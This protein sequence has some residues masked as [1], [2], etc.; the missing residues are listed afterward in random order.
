MKTSY[1]NFAGQKYSLTEN[2]VKDMD[3]IADAEHKIRKKA[4]EMIKDMDFDVF[5]GLKTFDD[6]NGGF[7]KAYFF[8]IPIERWEIERINKEF[9]AN[10]QIGIYYNQNSKNTT[11]PFK[12]EITG[13]DY[14]HQ[15]ADYLERSGFYDVEVTQASG[16]QGIDIIA[17]KGGKKYGI[18]CKY[19]KGSVGNKAV[20][21]AFTGAKFYKCDIAA[22]MT[23]GKFTAS[24]KELAHQTG[25]MLW[26][27][28]R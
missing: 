15:C 10:N 6:I 17:W 18:Q 23:T 28:T 11:P 1:T 8:L 3:K 21:E 25:V 16:D 13:F 19:Y 20:Q 14:E 2:T 22:V 26:E 24:A 5:Y 9:H 27:N 7:K 4:E 12:Q